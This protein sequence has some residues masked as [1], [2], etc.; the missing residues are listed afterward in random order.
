M[1][2]ENL[3]TDNTGSKGMSQ[4]LLEGIER[5]GN[6]VPHPVL[7]FLYLI[8]FIILL[9][10]LLSA[11]GVSVTDEI[12]VPV[13]TGTYEAY[14]PDSTEPYVQYPEEPYGADFEIQQ[15]TVA[16]QS[17]LSVAGI[18]FIFTSF[19]TNFAGFSVVAVILVAMVGWAWLKNPA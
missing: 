19:V 6:K 12:A 10:A 15:T 16:V 7:M 8:I 2:Q 9:S 4:K 1:S 14:F 11:L 5:V 17:L 13:D 18:R 3:E